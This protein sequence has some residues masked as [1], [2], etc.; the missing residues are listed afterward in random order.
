M[1][2]EMTLPLT[3]GDRSFVIDAA[4]AHI[5]EHLLD[6][7]M[8]PAAALIM[9]STAT[10]VIRR[11]GRSIGALATATG[12]QPGDERSEVHC[13]YL[14]PKWRGKGCASAALEEFS[15]ASPHPP[16]LREPLPP[17][18]VHA[19]RS[20]EIP[21]GNPHDVQLLHTV[22]ES[23]KRT[24]PCAHA[25]DPCRACMSTATRT[26]SEKAFNMFMAQV[27]EENLA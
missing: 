8:L 6:T 10:L 16:Y 15:R 2:I 1:I 7:G 25:S 9:A 17:A 18:L 11:N 4:C 22:T 14:L 26:F 19:A 13:L 3:R 27:M 20:L 5:D 23:F 21:T 24:V 12:G